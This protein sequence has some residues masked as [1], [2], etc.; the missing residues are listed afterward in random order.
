M[1]RPIDET[2]NKYG[3][4]TVVERS[5]SNRNGKAQ[6]AC[7]CEC[8]GTLVTNGTYLRNGETKSCGCLVVDNAS[9][10]GRANTTHGMTDTKLFYTWSN[11]IDRCTNPNSV[12]FANYGGRGISVCSE[13]LNSFEQFYSDMG[14]KPSQQHSLE[15]VDNN[16]GYSP[17]NCVW[18]TAKAQANNR[19][20]QGS[21]SRSFSQGV[22]DCLKAMKGLYSAKDIAKQYGCHWTTIYRIWRTV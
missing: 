18:A 2:G 20:L 8:G 7:Q 6:W 5:G 21:G 1:T 4:L 3:R 19:R 10:V 17:F 13:W 9:K 12:N 16:K 15:R 22:A 11:M 14:D